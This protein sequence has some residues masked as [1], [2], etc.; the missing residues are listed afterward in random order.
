MLE[1]RVGKA[2]GTVGRETII[3]EDPRF[4]TAYRVIEVQER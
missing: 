2:F 1:E 3:E 4:R